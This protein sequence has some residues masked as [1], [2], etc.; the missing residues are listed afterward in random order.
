[1]TP[2]VAVSLALVSLFSWEQPHPVVQK[3]N[4]CALVTKAEVEAALKSTVAGE[5]VPGA[6]GPMTTCRFDV[7]SGP[8]KG[9]WNL[10]VMACSAEGFQELAK[11]GGK[12]QAVDHIGDQASW[13]GDMLTVRKGNQCLL[14]PGWATAPDSLAVAKTLS[15]QAASRVWK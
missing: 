6:M 1:M 7:K 4:A 14:V 8:V 15:A 2:I 9:L 11:A 5:P 12:P 10:Q 3:P 13:A